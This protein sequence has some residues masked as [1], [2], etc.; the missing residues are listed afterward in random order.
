[1]EHFIVLVMGII[2]ISLYIW[3]C[4][5][6]GELMHEKG[7]NGWYTF[8]AFFIPMFIPFF[9]CAPYRKN[10]CGKCCNDVKKD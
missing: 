5:K 9:F 3:L 8:A 4:V 7:Y 6:A 10:E 1:M 2:Y